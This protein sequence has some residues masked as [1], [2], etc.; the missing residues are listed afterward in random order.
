MSNARGMRPI[1]TEWVIQYT[2]QF[3]YDA[4]GNVIYI[5]RADIGNATSGA[6]WQIRKMTYDAVGNLLT[7][8]FAN[9]NDGYTSIWDNRASL[10]YS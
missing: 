5:G 3:D 8:Q 10:S 7:I 1:S 4:N 2:Q 9:G 6:K